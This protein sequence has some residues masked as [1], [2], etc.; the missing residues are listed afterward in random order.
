VTLRPA[1]LALLLLAA[2]L[3]AQTAKPPAP[4]PDLRAIAAMVEKGELGPAEERLRRILAQGGGP[5]ARDLL[6]VVL[7][8]Q[9]RLGEAERE[10]RQA[11]VADP[12]SLGAHQHLA[13]LYL[14]QKRDAEAAAELRR[15]ARLGPLE[16]DLG[17][18]LARIERA[19]G[20]PRLAE[21]QLRSVADRFRS[22]HALLELARLQSAEKDTS[23]ALESLRRARVIAPSSEEL[24]RASAEAS[25]A[26]HAPLPAIEALEP[27]TRMCPAVGH[28]HYLQGIALMQAGDVVAA[29]EPLKEAERLEPNQPLALIA[30]GTVLDDRGLHAEARSYLLRSLDLE[31]GNVDAL[32][33]L[34]EAEEGL[35]ELGE[36]AAHAQRAL[37][38][39]STHATANLVMGMVL[40]KQ[41]RYAEARDALAK[42]AA[43]EPASPKAHYQLSLACARLNDE[44]SAQKHLEL[45]RQK[46]KEIEERVKEVRA[47]TGF[48]LGGMQPRD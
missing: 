25:L 44:A 24:L 36:A 7:V 5:A 16:R 28:Y 20:H 37:A 47:L 4:G 35:G 41:E 30:L 15:A 11:L 33:T 34:A 32:A 46:V 17:L 31:P 1:R 14:S 27:L 8:K 19:D 26:A 48:S 2:P 3:A 21:Q 6:G 12:G 13:R 18:G 38:R 23:G 39:A 40:M 9:G 22:A 10:L 29:V 42:A 43:A 45:Y